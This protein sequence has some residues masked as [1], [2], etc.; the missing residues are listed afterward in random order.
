MRFATPEY[1][2][3]GVFAIALIGLFV[4]WSA[5]KKRRLLELFADKKLISG[6]IANFSLQKRRYKYLLLFLGLIFLVLALARPQYGTHM[7][8][9]KREG[10]D[11]MLVVDCSK[12]MLAEDMKPNRL[13]KAKQ[14]VRGLISRMTGDRVGL[15][16]F[17]GAAFTECPLTLDYSAA[18]MFVDVLDV[19]LIPTPGTNIGAA[20]E[21]ATASF[22]QKERK[23]KVMIIITDGEDFG[24]DIKR[25]I[26]EAKVQGVKIY[27]IGLGKPEGEPIPIRNDRGEMIGYKKDERGDLVLTRLDEQMLQEIAA[28]ADGRYYHASAGEIA[29]DQI[30]EDINAMEKKEQKGMLMTQYEDRY[31]YVLPFAIICLGAE[32]L[33]SERKSRRKENASDETG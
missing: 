19:D 32:I 7:V 21:A 14:E 16:A 3:L 28:D 20:I 8:M 22:N 24:G 27:T 13:D 5:R 9:L 15:V 30:Y 2:Y 17:A 18:Q 29:L 33:I 10:Q 4:L 23:N 1:F 11:V 6:L 25:A 12:S 31:Q 26:K